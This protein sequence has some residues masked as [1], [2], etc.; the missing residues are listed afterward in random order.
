MPDQL[1]TSAARKVEYD[2]KKNRAVSSMGN[3]PI[4][5]NF[6]NRAVI[7]AIEIPMNNDPMNIDTKSPIAERNE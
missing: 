4:F 7:H 2:I 6:V 1:A 3:I 5:V